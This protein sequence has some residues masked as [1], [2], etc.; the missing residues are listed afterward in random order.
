MRVFCR[1]DGYVKAIC[2]KEKCKL[3]IETD[4]PDKDKTS[5]LIIPNPIDYLAE[6]N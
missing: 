2:L 1:S 5:K 4:E 6:P 3:K